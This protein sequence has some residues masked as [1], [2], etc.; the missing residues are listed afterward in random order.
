MLYSS[1]VII[2]TLLVGNCVLA[3]PSLNKVDNKDLPEEIGI[4]E[5]SQVDS[6]I[7]T[8]GKYYAR[9]VT[10]AKNS[11]LVDK[12]Y[13][14]VSK[15]DSVNWPFLVTTRGNIILIR[16]DG[17]CVSAL[18]GL[19]DGR[20]QNSNGFIIKHSFGWNLYSP[21]LS[22]TLD[23]LWKDEATAYQD[24]H[25]GEI[26]VSKLYVRLPNKMEKPVSPTSS[27]GKDLLAAIRTILDQEDQR[28]KPV[29]PVTA[30]EVA[31]GGAKFG[32]VR[33]ELCP[34][35]QAQVFLTKPNGELRVWRNDLVYKTIPFRCII[36]MDYGN[37][38]PPVI[39]LEGE[40]ESYYLMDNF[41][42]YENVKDAL[43]SDLRAKAK[44]AFDHSE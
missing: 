35:G 19:A 43:Y 26:N 9:K 11:S 39:I 29:E 20:E 32:W 31:R 37:Y 18:Y 7:V 30:S 22:N 40:D 41:M 15:V 28:V 13:N 25:I 10:R 23:E 6:V 42:G 14:S 12:I 8:I 1:L 27:D 16:K 33:A 38:K 34:S 24:A 21:T 5:S 3:E 44:I 17:S 36:V 2:F 4:T